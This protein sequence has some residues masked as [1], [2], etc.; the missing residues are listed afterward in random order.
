[1]KDIKFRVWHIPEKRMYFRGYQ[2]WFYVLLCDDDKGQSGGQGVPVKRACYRDCQFMEWTGLLDK[3][4]REIYEEDRIRITTGDR[5]FEEIVGA[6]PD[7]FG[8]KNAHPLL[9]IF[10]KHLVDPTRCVLEVI[11]TSCETTP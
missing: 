10:K 1:M 4:G 3:N 2:K 8:S 7:S 6:V 5:S 11:G 9:D